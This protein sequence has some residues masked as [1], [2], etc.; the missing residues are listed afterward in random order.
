MISP[1]CVH[2]MQ[3]VHRAHLYSQQIF[4][5]KI[6]HLIA[7]FYLYAS[8]LKPMTQLTQ[9]HEHCSRGF[10]C[11]LGIDVP[12]RFSVLPCKRRI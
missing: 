4:L 1:L 6:L 8:D 11:S 12:P 9:L 3:S 10:E 2:V 7:E 5:I